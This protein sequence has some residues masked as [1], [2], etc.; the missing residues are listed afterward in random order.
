MPF[1]FHHCLRER[2][3]EFTSALNPG[4]CEQAALSIITSFSFFSMFSKLICWWGFLYETQEITITSDQSQILTQVTKQNCF[5]N[6]LRVC[7]YFPAIKLMMLSRFPRRT[8]CLLL[9]SLP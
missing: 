8:Q 6:L 4:L 7:S 1:T 5:Q 2:P 9:I 3:G